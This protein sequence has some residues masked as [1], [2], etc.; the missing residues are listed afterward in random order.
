MTSPRSASRAGGRGGSEELVEAL[1]SKRRQQPVPPPRKFK[2][3]F[4]LLAQIRGGVHKHRTDDV[5][6]PLR[7]VGLVLP[8]HLPRARPL[9]DGGQQKSKGKS[10]LVGAPR[11][12]SNKI[13]D[14][15]RSM[16]WR[17]SAKATNSVIRGL[18]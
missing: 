15:S 5:K 12:S 16:P 4:Q 11:N 14:T 18:D 10:L 6:D 9:Q 17:R 13:P 3:L 8:V 1:E 7:E 2:P